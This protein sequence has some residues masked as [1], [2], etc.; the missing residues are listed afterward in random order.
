MSEVKVLYI[1]SM[2]RSGSTLFGNVLGQVEGFCDVGELR[3]LWGL[4]LLGESVC[5]CGDKVADCLF[6]TSVT[7]NAIVGDRYQAA[8]R[9][10]ELQKKRLGTR[11]ILRAAAHLAGLRSSSFDSYVQALVAHYRAIAGQTDSAVVVDGSKSPI[12]ALLLS[13]E[14]GVDLYI[15]HLVRDPRGVAYSLL[16]KKE[17]F[18]E[19]MRKKSR[20]LR[21]AIRWDIRNLLA[22]ALKLR[23]R[24]RYM[25]VRYEDFATQPAKELQRVLDWMGEGSSANP[26]SG[27]NNRLTLRPTHTAWGNR[28]RHKNGTIM[29]APDDRW[30]RVMRPW[31][32]TLATL[33]A[34][35]LMRR[36]RYRPLEMSGAVPAESLDSISSSD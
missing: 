22:E 2:G 16:S 4:G 10:V 15:L 12:D 1:L 35:P 25:R 17:Q 27:L 5:G 33:P 8:V 28:S 32:R 9:L 14:A 31:D 30:K 13:A 3:N 6:W 36:Y 24:E 23:V 11:H 20:P 21:T 19:E 34:L 7:E 18:G 29:I 26:M